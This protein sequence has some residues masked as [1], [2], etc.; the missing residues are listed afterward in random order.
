MKKTLIIV[1]VLIIIGLLGCKKKVIDVNKDFIG[2]W[3][4]ESKF[5]KED[6][7]KSIEI[8]DNSDGEYSE[9]GGYSSK[10]A[11]GKARLKGKVLKIGVKKFNVDSEPERLGNV[12]NFWAMTIS[13][14]TYYTNK[15][16]DDGVGGYCTPTKL[17]VWNTGTSSIQAHMDGHAYTILPNGILE[18]SVNCFGCETKYYDNKGNSFSFFNIACASTIEIQ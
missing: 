8:K 15:D 2:Q 10:Q 9:R 16:A 4:S 14:T 3:Y 13:G 17:S 5:K 1:H 7:F 18:S 12:G 11:S 6:S